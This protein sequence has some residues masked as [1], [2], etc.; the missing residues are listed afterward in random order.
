MCKKSVFLLVVGLMCAN[1]CGC[2]DMSDIEDVSAVMAVFVDRDSITYCTVT[3]SSEEKRYNYSLYETDNDN[4]YQGI[5]QLVVRTGKEI[6]LSHIE[7]ILFSVDCDNERVKDNLNALLGRTNSHP[8]A[9]VAYFEGDG[10]DFASKVT[11]IADNGDG[12]RLRQILDNRFSGAVVCNAM[13]LCYALNYSASG[14]TAPVVAIAGDGLTYTGVVY[15]DSNRSVYIGKPYSDIV[16]AV[17]NKGETVT[18][19]EESPVE[20]RCVSYDVTYE[21]S[22]NQADIEIRFEYG[23]YGSD[24]DGLGKSV[25]DGLEYIYDLRKDGYDILH[26][27]N[28]IKKSC[29][30][31]TAFERFAESYGGVAA[32]VGDMDVDIRL[33]IERERD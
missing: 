27:Y 4:I 32:C 8:K 14:V 22:S 9:P 18:Y 24:G 17:L 5:H 19:G 28:F 1:L 16:T 13:E 26:L 10:Y 2:Y 20:I 21:K 23:G 15:A 31:I 25:G 29:Y 11:D 3:A 6:S 33:G 7:A 30:T 12:K